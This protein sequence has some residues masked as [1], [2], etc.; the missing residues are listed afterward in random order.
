[1]DQNQPK[2]QDIKMG[3]PT[4]SPLGEADK[5]ERKQVGPIIV[6][7]VVV[8]VL[9]IA[10]LYIF[11]SQLNREPVPDAESDAVAAQNPAAAQSVPE[12]F[13]TADD[14]QS[15]QNDLDRSTSGLEGQNF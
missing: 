10:G 7:L 11:A 15:I 3:A 2:E 4:A 14:P 5:N 1:M 8:L 13:S 12:V 9:I 6:T